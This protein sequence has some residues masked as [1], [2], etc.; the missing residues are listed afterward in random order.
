MYRKKKEDTWELKIEYQKLTC[1]IFSGSLFLR[2][3]SGLQLVSP[4]LHPEL[5]ECFRG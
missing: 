2:R 3:N 5:P 1:R 4:C